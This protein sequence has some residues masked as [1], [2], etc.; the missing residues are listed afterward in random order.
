MT[1]TQMFQQTC[2]HNARICREP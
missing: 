2:F 1:N